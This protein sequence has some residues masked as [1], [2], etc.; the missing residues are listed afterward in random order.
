MTLYVGVMMVL[1]YSLKMW[2]YFV[3]KFFHHTL[4]TVISIPSFDRYIFISF[5]L[6]IYSFYK[7]KS[8]ENAMSFKN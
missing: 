1:K 6:N 4:D 5:K 8:D 7:S 2:T 3:R